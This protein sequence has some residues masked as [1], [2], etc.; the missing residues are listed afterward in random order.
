MG[1]YIESVQITNFA[2]LS[3]FSL[4]LCDGLN[5]VRGDNE[6]GKS[7]VADFIRFVLYGFSGKPDREKH[8]S[9]SS[10]SAE[11]SLI[12]REEDKRYR[13]ERKVTESRET[14]GVFDLDT[15]ARC[16]EGRVPGEVFFGI[17]ASLFTSTAFVGQTDGSRINGRA[18]SE[19]VDNLLFSADEGINSRKALKKLE[20]MRTAL[21]YKN[22]KGGVLYELDQKREQLNQRFSRAVEQS[23]EILTLETGNADLTR[24]LESE[25]EALRTVTGQIEDHRILDSRRRKERLAELEAA[26]NR[27]AQAAEAHHR[28]YE[29]DGF[30]PDN[31]YLENL[32]TCGS[33][34]VRCDNEVK[35]IEAD[36]NELNEEI[37]RSREE[38]EKLDR[39]EEA[40]RAVLS[41]KRGTALAMGIVCCVL[42][43]LSAVLSAVLFITGHRNAGTALAVL[44][45]VMFGGMIGGF[46]LS[47]RF[48]AELRSLARGM[49]RKD[50]LFEGRLEKIGRE[51][52]SA[53]DER[54]K[55]RQLL[56]ELCAKWHI[57]PSGK[58]LTELSNVL[59]E[60]KQLQRAQERSR[61]AYVQ[62]KAETE[63]QNR[64]DE[65][66]D[67]GRTISLP[68]SFD[69]KEAYRRQDLLTNMIRAH[70]EM[71]HRGEVRL[72]ALNATAESPSAIREAITALEYERE[73]GQEKY[74]AC[75]LAQEKIAEAAE[76]LRADVSPKLSAS[77]GALM[78]TVTDGKYEELGVGSAFAMTFRPDAGSGGRMTKDETFMSAGTADVAYVSLRLSLVDM[79]CREARPPMIFDESFSRLD[80]IRLLN[81][82]RLLIHSGRQVILLSSSA[83][84]E[85]LLKKTGLTW[86]AVSLG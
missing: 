75:V 21:L 69:P 86:H 28:A 15:G 32:K 8:L 31:A 19:A 74:D 3:G 34:I 41:A 24:K 71:L 61:F 14:G 63:A 73:A 70:Q 64:A 52:A 60:E 43:L 77:A 12:L 46:V 10:Q 85:A 45:A 54:A 33:E 36:L 55:Y 1:I 38:R 49:S 5:V 57:V 65:V 40:E 42:L 30:F 6:S 58:A 83:R 79:I 67:D 78:K 81:M 48:T 80:D 25:A 16:F 50:D 17:P 68:E 72:A 2:A 4:D 7:T 44:A 84:E 82:L 23:G 47:S 9:F 62:M 51:L 56:D 27:D 11:G 76:I 18:A 53:R 66:E 20:E 59:S 13:V 39:E 29:R 26:F 22:K 37:R 35:R